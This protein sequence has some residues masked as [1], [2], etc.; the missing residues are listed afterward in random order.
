MCASAAADTRLRQVPRQSPQGHQGRVADAAAGRD[1]EVQEEARSASHP[2][3]H[4]ARFP[5]QRRPPASRRQDRGAARVV[6]GTTQTAQL[7]A[8]VPG[9]CRALVGVVCD[10][11]RGRGTARDRP[12]DRNRLG[13]QGDR[14]HHIKRPRPSPPAARPQGRAETR[15]LSADDGPA[16][17]AEGAGRIEGSPRGAGASGRSP[18]LP[19]LTPG[20][21]RAALCAVPRAGRSPCG[22]SLPCPGRRASNHGRSPGRGAVRWG[23]RPVAAAARR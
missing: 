2:R 11:R 3:I 6:A 22:G 19:R 20:E 21:R 7:G 18:F 12:R 23:R 14:D 17:A 8:R 5:P 1:A 16:T 15:P 13:R 4:Q 9:Q 10:G